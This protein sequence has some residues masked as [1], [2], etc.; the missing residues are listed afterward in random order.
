MVLAHWETSKADI[1][2]QLLLMCPFD[3]LRKKY[4]DRLL[5]AVQ[6]LPQDAPSWSTVMEFALLRFDVAVLIQHDLHSSVV[7]F[8]LQDVDREPAPWT[9]S[10]AYVVCALVMQGEFAAAGRLT[11]ALRH[12]HPLLWDVENARLLLSSYL[13]TLAS[14]SVQHSTIYSAELSHMKHEVY[15]QTSSRFAKA[16]D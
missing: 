14:L 10:G 16:F 1:A 12:A 9:S 2:I 3:E 5:H 13:R 7:A 11:C 4:T 8:L 6:Q 15:V